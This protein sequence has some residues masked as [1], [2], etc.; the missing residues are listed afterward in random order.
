MQRHMNVKLENIIL[1]RASNLSKSE[2]FALLRIG[3]RPAVAVPPFC[4][5]HTVSIGV[6]KRT[7]VVCSQPMLELTK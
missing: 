2:Q 1:H 7:S 3:M 5:F 6:H 4:F